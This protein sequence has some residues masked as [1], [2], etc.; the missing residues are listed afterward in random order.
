MNKLDLD[1]IISLKIDSDDRINNL[2]KIVK[3][4]QEEVPCNIILC[5]QDTIPKLEGRYVCQYVFHQVDEFFNKHKGLNLA[6][7]RSN[8]SVLA[9]YDADIFMDPRQLIGA[10]KLINNKDFDL[11]YPYDGRFYDVPKQ[12]HS[13]I[14]EFDKIPLS[15][16]KLFNENS[17]GGV[18]FFNREVFISGGGANENF[19]G[20]GYDD[21]EIYIRYMNLGYRIARVSGPLY[22]LNHTRKDTAFDNNPFID[23]NRDEYIRISSLSKVELQKEI[24]TWNHI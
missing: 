12:Y 4:L 1:I 9:Y 15:E 22:H 23:F 21:N 3:F 10:Y 24:T 2:D 16:C 17:V 20:L 7:K 13:N 5:E 6:V 14:K 11:V 18:V 8:A 19:K